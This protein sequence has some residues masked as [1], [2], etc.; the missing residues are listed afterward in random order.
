[1]SKAKLYRLIYERWLKMTRRCLD[2]INKDYPRYGG[3]GIRVF[4]GWLGPLGFKRYLDY[5]TRWLP[6]PS[7]LPLSEA[8]LATGSEKLTLDRI[9]N[10]QG[11]EPG[12]LRWALPVEQSANQ[13]RSVFVNGIPRSHAARLWGVDPRTAA[14]RQRLGYSGADAVSLG[15]GGR[16]AEARRRRDQAILTMIDA[17]RLFVDGMGFILVRDAEMVGTSASR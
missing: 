13:R 4:K 16:T 8:L 7:G 11:Y 15:T 17:G 3:R 2:K 5:V 10:M 1:M 12:N 9:D 6:V 14:R